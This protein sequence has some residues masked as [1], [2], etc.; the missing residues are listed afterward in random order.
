ME[1]E[2]KLLDYAT[3]SGLSITGPALVAIKVQIK[4]TLKP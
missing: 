4:A 3:D 1:I 2:T